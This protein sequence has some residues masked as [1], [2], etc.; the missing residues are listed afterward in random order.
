[1]LDLV[2][3]VEAEMMIGH[4]NTLIYR[5][6]HFKFESKLLNRYVPAKNSKNIG[7]CCGTYK[8]H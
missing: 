8:Y 6:L 1:L 5:V 7:L 2:A 3:L 4:G